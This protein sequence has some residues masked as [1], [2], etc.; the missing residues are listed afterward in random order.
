[1]FCSCCNRSY[2]Q[3]FDGKLKERFLNTYKYSNHDNNNFVLLSRKRVYTY[4]YMDDW[5]NSMKNN[6]LKKKIFVVT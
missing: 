2:H 5:E 3:K 6:Y 4:E 1:M